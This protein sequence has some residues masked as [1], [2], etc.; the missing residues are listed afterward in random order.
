MGKSLQTRREPGRYFSHKSNLPL[1][2]GLCLIDMSMFLEA[3]DIFLK[4]SLCVSIAQVDYVTQN[5][6][7]SLGKNTQVESQSET[8]R[9]EWLFWN[10]F[11]HR[12]NLN[13][14]ISHK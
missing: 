1:F 3:I 11:Q 4:Y 13:N 9:Q 8:V 12:Y 2:K 10:D 6:N 14:V 5:K 7:S